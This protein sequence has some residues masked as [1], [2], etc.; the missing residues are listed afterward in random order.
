[1]KHKFLIA[2]L[3]FSTIFFTARAYPDFGSF[4]GNSDYSTT[5]TQSERSPSQPSRPSYTRTTIPVRSGIATSRT[6]TSSD[7]TDDD[8]AT[9]MGIGFVFLI[10]FLYWLFTHKKA[11]QKREIFINAPI[12]N[13]NPMNEYLALDHNFDGERITNLLANLYVQMQ[14]TWHNKDISSLRPYMTDE[15]YSQMDRQ[16]DQFRHGHKTDFTE[17]IAVLGVSLKGWRQSSG[18]DYITAVLN[19]RI[20]SYT[21]DDRTGKL[22]SGDRSREKFMQYEIDLCRKSGTIT[23]PETSGQQSAICPHCGAPLRLNAS[24]QCEYCGSIITT[25]NTNWAICAM[26]GISQRSA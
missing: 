18:F 23:S 14:D 15:F 11:K 8:I 2:L 21:L 13:L 16:L 17:N 10:F 20:T 19:S 3:I 6:R 1:M 12:I 25:T 26:R 5:S 7:D 22:L 24:A 4:S 9:C